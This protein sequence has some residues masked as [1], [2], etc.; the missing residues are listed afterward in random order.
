MCCNVEVAC[1]TIVKPLDFTIGLVTDV[2]IEHN[3]KNVWMIWQI[4]K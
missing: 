4:Q 2:M 3:L 1:D